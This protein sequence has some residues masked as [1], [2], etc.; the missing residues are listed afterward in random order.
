MSCQVRK[1]AHA[2]RRAEFAPLYE[3]CCIAAQDARGLAAWAVPIYCGPGQCLVAAF[4]LLAGPHFGIQS[5]RLQQLG[6]SAAFGQSALVEHQ[7]AVGI[8]DRR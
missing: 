1:M 5:A 4:R 3:R 6:M 2:D 8:G 7:D